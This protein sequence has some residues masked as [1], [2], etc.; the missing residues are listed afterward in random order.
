V[1]KVCESSSV[2]PHV[3]QRFILFS[4]SRFEKQS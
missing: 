3:G 4:G 1:Q 2:R